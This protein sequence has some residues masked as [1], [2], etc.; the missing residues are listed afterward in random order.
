VRFPLPRLFGRCQFENDLDQEMR[1]HIERRVEDL[2][3]AGVP[4]SSAERQARIEFG[5]LESAKEECREASGFR[6]IDELIADTRH[7]VRILRRSPVFALVAIVALSIGIGACTS[8]FSVV[9]SILLRPL[10]YRN[11]DR[12]VRI[13]TNNASLRISDGPTSYPDFVDWSKS[14]ILETSC[15]YSYQNVVITM[16][17]VSERVLAGIGTSGVFSTFDVAPVRGRLFTAA[18]DRLSDSPAVILTEDFWRR[19]FGGDESIVG[20]AVRID[21]KSLT[22]VGIVPAFLNF[23]GQ[24][25]V[26]V[27]PPNI[28]GADE[29]ANRFWLTAGRTRP[30]MT[31]QQAQERLRQL[32]RALAEAYPASNKGW[33]VDVADLKETLVGDTRTELLVLSGSV[34]FVLLIVCANVAALYVVR[35]TVRERELSIRASLGASGARI[36]RQLITESA[37]IALI[38]AGLGTATAAGAV[39]L[40]REHGPRDLPRLEEVQVDTRALLFAAGLAIF[41][42]LLSGVAPAVQS[43]RRNPQSGMRAASRVMTEGRRKGLTRAAL[44]SAEV[45]LSVMLLSGAALLVKSFRALAHEDLG[46]RADHLLTMFVWMPS[47]KF[48]DGDQYQSVKVE[49]YIERLEAGLRS[50]PGVSNVGVGMYA[51]V[52]GGG[53][54]TW[55]Q[56]R[57]F[58]D[59][60]REEGMVH[61]IKQVVTPEYFA[62]L[63][64]PLRRGRVFNSSDSP[65]SNAVALINEAFARTRFGRKNPVGRRVVLEDD[66]KPREI[67]GVVGNIQ[68]GAPSELAPAQVFV[69]EAQNPV[70]MLTVFV[71]TQQDPAR[72]VAAVQ[73]RVLDVDPDVPAY[74]VRSAEE[75]VSRSLATKRVVMQL[76]AGFAGLSVALAL[77]GL[78]GV[79]AYSVARRT[80]EFGVR[81]ALGAQPVQVVAM[82]LRQGLGL[83]LSGVGCGLLAAIALARL[84]GGLLY[85]VSPRDPA[86][87][88]L[89]AAAVFAAAIVSWWMPARRAAK[90]D[91]A[92]TLRWE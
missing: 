88:S 28:N 20:S 22:V 89:V 58:G 43:V 60:E 39:S 56:F 90:V 44:V 34:L 49:Q 45:A 53:Y 3:R 41:V 86:V 30:G 84:L 70:P 23:E 15:I 65:G 7:T 62:T 26:W 9:N 16:H 67:V 52:G 63:G 29:R 40:I 51:P 61:G 14:G 54:Q 32:C 50:L 92:V 85:R 24:F 71:R 35:G 13:L 87:L 42:G 66:P 4:K 78:Y 33:S 74:R 83:V 82:V 64:I 36:L 68:P 81:V 18:D 12:I 55:Q 48:L 6:P 2:V 76:M 38:A 8:M 10:P 21:G 72:L 75:L 77:I 19:R 1:A 57:V 17:G 5:A 59:N 31:R 25:D 47:T 69:P 11:S 91:P 80:R 27:A 73:R 46:F 37:V 79:L